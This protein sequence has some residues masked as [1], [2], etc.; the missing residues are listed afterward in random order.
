MNIKRTIAATAVAAVA[1]VGFAAT[2]SAADDYVNPYEVPGH[3]QQERQGKVVTHGIQSDTLDGS[4]D[5]EV[6]VNTVGDF[7]GDPNLNDGQ[8]MNRYLCD[9][10]S[11]VTYHIFHNT[12]PA[13]DNLSEGL[14][15]V[16]GDWGYFETSNR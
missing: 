15:T 5:C 8:M 11:V 6:I 16:W 1:S 4:Q 9:D 10:G 7:G 12:H 3:A 13:Y 14:V 2:A